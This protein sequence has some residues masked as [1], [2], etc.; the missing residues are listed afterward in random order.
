MKFHRL[1]DNKKLPE[2]SSSDPEE[3]R[4][5][6]GLKFKVEMGGGGLW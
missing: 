6:K 2:P 5:Q 3:E 4:I 1:I